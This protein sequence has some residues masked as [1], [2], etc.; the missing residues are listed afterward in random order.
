MADPPAAAAQGQQRQN[1]L[2]GILRMI[3]MWYMFKTFFGGSS[4]KPL[5]R[6]ELFM[7]QYAK[8]TP[9][10]MSLFLTE[11]PSI[12]KFSDSE[13]LIWQEKDIVY[14]TDPNRVFNYTYTPTKVR[15][16]FTTY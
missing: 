6:E 7:P 8:G 11:T 15:P 16:A 9:F 14:G 3:A 2:F 1:P 4:K 10:D 12:S 13:A 5:T